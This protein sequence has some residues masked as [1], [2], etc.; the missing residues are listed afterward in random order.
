M[1]YEFKGNSNYTLGVELELQ[2][3]DRE[4][5]ALAN[6]VQQIL[7]RVP[8]EFAD[9]IK[10]EFMQSYC[11]INT[12]VCQNVTEVEQDLATKLHWLYKVAGELGMGVIWAGSHPFSLWKEQVI[13]PGERYAWLM[14][15]MQYVARR[16]VCFG[17]HVHVGVD[18]GDKAIQM[19]DR[20]LRH[21]P[22]LLAL[23]ANSPMW[24]GMNTGMASHR[25]KIMEALPTAGLPYTMR[26]WSEYVWLVDHLIATNFLHSIREIW[27]DVRPHHLFGT[28]EIR[29]MDMP[30]NLHHTLGLVALCQSLVA[31]IS[32]NIDRGAYLY[33]CHP[34]IAKQN[35]WH[36]AR[37]GMNA[38]FV[39]SDT[40]QAVP[41]RDMA[42][43][44]IDRCSEQAERLGC[45]EQMNYLNDIIEH[46][47]GAERQCA[48][49][50]RNRDA[51]EVARFL[52]DQH[53]QAAVPQP[54]GSAEQV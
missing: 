34:M 23:S 45:L 8:E 37:Y 32:E 53:L 48:V 29:I 51:H 46:G 28:V 6:T 38:T 2:L 11:E 30:L 24:C 35:K 42:R 18:T 16:L 15:T 26:N 12:A 43:K 52:A 22:T 27:W 39:D 50:E 31:A 19:C 47:T 3:V 1:S 33:D 17:L 20:L 5:C 14:D 21:L 7:K 4:T 40:M 44:L 25:S 41:A 49:Y 54:Q 13:S 9:S 10:P 36:A